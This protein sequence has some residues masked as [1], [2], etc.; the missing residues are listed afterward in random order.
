MIVPTKAVNSIAIMTT[1]DIP[2]GFDTLKRIVKPTVAVIIIFTV[3]IFVSG[4]AKMT[5]MRR[6]ARMP[7]TI[8][9]AAER[10]FSMTFARNLPRGLP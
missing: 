8:V 5:L 9:T 10:E 6:A 7:I 2:K 3:E 4:R 1:S